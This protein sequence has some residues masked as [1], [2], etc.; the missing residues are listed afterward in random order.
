MEGRTMVSP[1][2]SPKADFDPA[3]AA[4][5]DRV[6]TLAGGC[7]WCVEAVYRQLDGV[8][9]VVNGYAG[10]TAQTADYRA[11]STGRTGHAE[12]VQVRYDP[13]RV[14]Y[15]DLL[16]IFFSIAHDPTTRDRQGADVGP[17]DR[18]E[19]FAAAPTD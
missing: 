13:A 17:Q 3:P 7:F 12:A 14:S 10:G 5:G 6:A 4:A 18:R 15:G 2:Q 8:L 9:D 1:E 19:V 16:R 11:V